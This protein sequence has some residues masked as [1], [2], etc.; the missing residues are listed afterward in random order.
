V[1]RI[2][3]PESTPI[4]EFVELNEVTLDSVKKQFV[5]TNKI[6]QEMF[7]Q[8]MRVTNNKLAY[9]VW[10]IK[11]ILDN[12][13][14]GEDVYKFKDYFRAFEKYKAQYPMKDINQYKTKEQVDQF[15]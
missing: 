2:K 12:S 1:N 5:D 15:K 9:A 13:L 8:I 11:R 3:L 10:M 7:D 4:K 6:P 14:L